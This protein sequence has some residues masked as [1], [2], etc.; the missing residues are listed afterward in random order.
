V[1]TIFNQFLRLGSVKSLQ[2]WLR[3]ND[4][5]SRRGEHFF[6]GPLYMMLRNTHYLGRIKH[7]TESVPGEHPAIIDRETWG[8]AQSLLDANIQGTRYCWPKLNGK[9][10]R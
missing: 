8:K 5:R 3:E 9:P 7:K 10:R 4:I 6:R 1:R 2:N